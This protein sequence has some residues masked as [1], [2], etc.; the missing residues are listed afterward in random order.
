LEIKGKCRNGKIG[1]M[2]RR[3]TFMKKSQIKYLRK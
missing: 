2:A 1:G 3:R